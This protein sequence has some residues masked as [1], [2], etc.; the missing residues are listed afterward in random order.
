MS[1][2]D[3]DA[4]EARFGA[5]VRARREHDPAVRDVLALTGEIR[6]L[7]SWGGLLSLLDQHWPA[8]IFPM[9]EQL[10]AAKST[11]RDTGPVVLG[12]IRWVDKL[13]A[14]RDRLRAALQDIAD[15]GLRADLNPTAPMHN[16]GQLY[17]H[18][19]GY[20]RRCDA[21]IREQARRALE[22]KP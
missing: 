8:D 19:V 13:T 3:L 5:E 2:L 9:A 7:H 14:E 15:H 17:D 6:R 12:L 21:G 1:E 4:I 20:L 16:T 18:L 22:P 10:D 11:R